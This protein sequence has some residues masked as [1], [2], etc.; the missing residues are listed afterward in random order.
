MRPDYLT[1][2]QKTI[3]SGFGNPEIQDQIRVSER[4]FGA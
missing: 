4:C 3:E 2:R 1:L